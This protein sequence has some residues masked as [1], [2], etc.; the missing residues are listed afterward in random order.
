MKIKCL[1]KDMKN[2]SLNFFFKKIK[3]FPHYHQLDID[4]NMHVMINIKGAV[5]KP[6]GQNFGQF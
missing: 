6:R 3:F 5:Y 4:L 2:I 1:K